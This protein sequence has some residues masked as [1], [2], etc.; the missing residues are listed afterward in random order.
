LRQDDLG[1]GGIISV[2]DGVVEQAHGPHHL[3]GPPHPIWEVGRISHHLKCNY[4][5]NVIHKEQIVQLKK[6]TCMKVFILPVA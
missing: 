1:T 6:V 2:G 3:A 4:H 5:E